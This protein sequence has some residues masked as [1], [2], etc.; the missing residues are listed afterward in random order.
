MRIATWRDEGSRLLAFDRSNPWGSKKCTPLS[1]TP[2]PH[3]AESEGQPNILIDPNGN[4]RLTDFGL[5]SITRDNRS[6]N[7]STPNGRGSTRWRA[8][9]LLALSTKAKGREKV[10]SARPTEKSDAYSLAMVVIEVV[11]PRLAQN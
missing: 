9:E 6:A 4:P 2:T 10:K 11:F 7:A 5:S 3:P 8:P 1:P